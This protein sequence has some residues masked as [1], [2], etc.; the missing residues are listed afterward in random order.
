VFHGWC[1]LRARNAVAFCAIAFFEAL[2]VAH[3]ADDVAPAT[4]AEAT[5]ATQKLNVAGVKVRLEFFDQDFRNGT[6]QLVVWIERSIGIVAGY[7]GRFPTAE[8]RLRVHSTDGSGVRHGTAFGSSPPRIRL[9]VGQEATAAELRRD[10]VLV[11]EMVH[12]ALP[13]VGRRH[14]WLSEGLATYVEGIAR[15]QA[16]NRSAKD[17]WAEYVRSM[18]QGLPRSGDEGLDNTHTWGRTYW[19]GALFCLQA[20]VEIRKRTNNRFGLR[21]ALRAVA[22]S[23][24]GLSFDWPIERVFATG[25]AAVGTT[26]LT[27][28]YA[29]AK[30]A[31]AAPD[32]DA[33][34]KDMGIQRR[35]ASVELQDDAPL[36]A[37]RD[38]I[39]R[40]P[41]DLP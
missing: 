9:Q 16:G 4:Q 34:W 5:S 12:L 33:L 37:I 19:G 28:L 2:R 24:G 3:A 14:A 10:W 36:A 32:L 39:M 41:D 6:A 38:A 8:L 17:V 20:D 27:D 23:S 29:R 13:E 18:P 40:A 11:H 31:P 22:K 7:Y 25:D 21:D 26:V 35:G 1:E 15:A 30:D